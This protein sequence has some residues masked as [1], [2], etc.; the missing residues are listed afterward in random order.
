MESTS[1]RVT[2]TSVVGMA[3]YFAARHVI[4]QRLAGRLLTGLRRIARQRTVPGA[5]S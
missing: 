1:T 5:E 3:R 2:L 4:C